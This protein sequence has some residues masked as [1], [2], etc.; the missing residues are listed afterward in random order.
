[1]G[2]MGGLI[3]N[4]VVGLSLEGPASSMKK[5]FGFSYLVTGRSFETH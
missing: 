1:M 4:F 3:M 2:S 5:Q